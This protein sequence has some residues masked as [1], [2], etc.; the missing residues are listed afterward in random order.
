VPERRPPVLVFLIDAFRHDFLSDAQTPRLAELASAGVRKPLQPILGY[1]DSIRATLF[2]GLPPDKTGY[3]MEYAYRPEASPWRGFDR[4]APLDRLPGDATRRGLKL[5]L[6]ATVMKPVAA[7][8]GLPHM[9]L[10][11]VPFRAIGQFDLTLHEP[12]TA[13]GALGH[14]TIFDECA[15]AGRPWAYL[16]S[17]RVR[18]G[19]DLVGRVA[20][21]PDDVGLVFV[22]LHQIDM[23]A[24]L[25][26]IE[27]P[28][29]WRRVRSTDD[30]FGRILDRLVGRF[31]D[32]RTVV[33]SDHGMSTLTR[34]V[35]IPELTSHPGFCTRFFAA[36]DA[37]MVRLWY[38]D[39]DEALR[40]ELRERVADRFPG[41]FLTPEE[42]SRY[43]L[44][45]SDRLYG[46]EFFLLPPG[47]A[48]FP[49]FHSFIRPKAMHAYAPEDRDQ[50]GIFVGPGD[51]APLVSDPV[52]LTEVTA[53]ISDALVPSGG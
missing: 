46:D 15:A 5:A 24:H 29:F 13:P 22:Y 14:P 34:Q 3:W 23:A 28:T 45:F 47:T 25:V 27:S 44:E 21:L 8:R 35:G 39:D 49:N 2:T 30:L 41:H 6:S 7:R 17:S 18:R 48:I 9:S 16:D 26:G 1:S 32:A 53:L 20:S 37:T 12:M 19:D 36:L 40:A 33:L 52:A 38:L 42:L 11:A 43:D 50:W 4:L 31:P 51:V 10:R